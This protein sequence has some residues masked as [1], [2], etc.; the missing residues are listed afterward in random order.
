M[1]VKF[2]DKKQINSHDGQIYQST[3]L[4]TEGVIKNVESTETVNKR[5]KIPKGQSK[6]ENPEKLY[7]NVTKYRRGNQKRRIQENCK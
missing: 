2:P 4:N 1:C 3:L 6:T 5:Y 7:I